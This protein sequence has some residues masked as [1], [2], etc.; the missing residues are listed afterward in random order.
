MLLKDVEILLLRIA[1]SDVEW[2]LLTC[3]LCFKS[4]NV[5]EYTRLVLFL[6]FTDGV[7]DCQFED[8]FSIY[9]KAMLRV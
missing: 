3:N 1:N 5:S 2:K 8:R 4:F 9:V 7:G 6:F